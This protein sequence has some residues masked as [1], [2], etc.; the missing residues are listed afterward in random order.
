VRDRFWLFQ[1]ISLAGLTP[2]AI[3][4]LGLILIM[5]TLQISIVAATGGVGLL[6]SLLLGTLQAVLINKFKNAFLDQACDA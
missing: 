2:G 6:T 3:I 5:L 4:T 1:G